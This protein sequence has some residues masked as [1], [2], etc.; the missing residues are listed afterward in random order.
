MGEGEQGEDTAGRHAGETAGRGTVKDAQAG[1]LT[2][3]GWLVVTGWVTAGVV[4]L[5]IALQHLWLGGWPGGTATMFA[6]VFGFLMAASWIW[7]I[8]LFVH[9][10]SD[11][12]D[13][14]EGFFVLMI[15]LMP[16]DLAVLV[17]AVVV[18]VAQLV[19]RRAFLRIVF[20]AG[21][22]VTATGAAALVFVLLDGPQHPT[23][24]VKIG[25]A[26]AGAAAYFVVNTAAIVTILTA[27]G[28]TWRDAL[29]GGMRVRL[30]VVIGT[31]DIAIPT[32][33]LL[34]FKPSFL[35]LALL[36][37]LV[38][39]YLGEGH[40][41]AR[42]DRIRL[43]GLFEATL[44]VNRS[45]GAEE[46]R[47]AVLASAGTLLR[48]SEVTLGPERPSSAATTL[49]APVEVAD[50]H[51]W[52]TVSGRR[53]GEP[54]A[55]GDRALLDALASVGGIALSNADLYAEV[56]RQRNSLSV[57]T[58]SLGEG[59]CA[60]TKSGDITFMNPAG[61]AMLGW[62]DVHHDGRPRA[63]R[64]TPRF[65]LDPALRAMSQRQNVMTDDTRFERDDGSY[66]PV[67]MTASPVVGGAQPSAAVIVFRDTSE[68][69]AFEE[70]LARHAFQDP[71]TGLAN[72]R[73]LLD[74]LD[75]ALRLAA[76]SGNKVAVLFGDVDRFKVVNDNLGH[77]V[78]DEL[79]RVIAERLRRA[80]R[81]GDTLSRFGGDEFVAILE[82]VQ[83]PDDAGQVADRILEVLREPVMLTGGH[84][85]VPTMS[86]GMA[87]SEE[88]MSR[89]D[90]L[91][92]ADVAMYRAKERGRGGAV[93]L[94]DVD[95]MGARSLGRL[96]LDTA[97]HHAVER[98][99]V[100]AYFQ[101]LVSLT[102]G[103]IVSAE[104][105]V[106]WDHPEHGILS[107][108]HFMEV[109]EDNG[110][111]LAIGT[112][113][114]EQA[115]R[116]AAAWTASFGVPVEVG[117]NLSA[118][119]FQQD[120]LDAQV[121]AVL[122]ATGIAPSQLCLEIT[123]SLAMDDVEMTSAVLAKLH[124]LG[125]RLAIDDFGTGHSS[126][127]YLAQ[128]PI[129]V[130]K[131]DQSF[132]QGIDQD[133]VKSAIVSAVVA[134]SQAIGTTTVA[135][136]VETSA[137]L[138]QIASLGCDLAQGFYFSRALPGSSFEALM[139]NGWQMAPATD[140]ISHRV[141]TG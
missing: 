2:T 53:H 124:N 47:S 26:L 12:F 116:A 134:L 42:D 64:V 28:N 128:F 8:T 81:P 14:D 48:S 46:T 24:Y 9:D 93:T 17:F 35:P 87:L 63:T 138:E 85:V 78:G 104:A 110:T 49:A 70:Q 127:G 66:F 122:E 56:E 77:Q 130:I 19:R 54:F 75:H 60:V 58:R 51:L 90:L 89:D 115:C 11:V 59:V 98:D 39:R 43:R 25:A 7:P 80:V 114:L 129:D 132:A 61:A 83:S 86:I 20:N 140:L 95:R 27:I 139:R 126:L 137:E 103:R 41:Y 37:L 84:E 120:D 21:R 131:I 106:R 109:A 88:G 68:R 133:P 16:A 125:L 22:V 55:E 74:H 76:R 5:G 34:S 36:P 97:L 57:I 92:D 10:Q 102:D 52:L 73:L 123:E 32:A 96:D 79:L 69:K 62:T 99:E 44:D 18:V 23:G 111:I 71:L 117:V 119:Q 121:A 29:F 112:V 141:L 107:P 100:Q 3:T 135:E 72:R 6:V 82:G 40:F 67:T 108:T 50:R 38:L 91:H 113:V 30:L 45:I 105:L 136:G 118:R 94:F 65:L 101:P 15:L 33:L 31:I 1:F 13:I 4:V